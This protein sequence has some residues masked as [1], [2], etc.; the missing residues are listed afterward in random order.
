MTGRD[1]SDAYWLD[2]TGRWVTST[3]YMKQLPKWVADLNAKR[4]ADGYLGKQWTA[5]LGGNTLGNSI[6]VS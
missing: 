5:L 4:P 2:G 1:A 6:T 3:W